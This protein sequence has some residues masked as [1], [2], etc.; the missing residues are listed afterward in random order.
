PPAPAAPESPARRPEPP[1]VSAD[2]AHGPNRRRPAVVTALLLIV[3]VVTAVV[4]TTGG[5]GGGGIE[6]EVTV[7]GGA[8]WVASG[9]SVEPGDILTVKVSGSIVHDVDADRSTGPDGDPSPDV[10]QFNIVPDF[11]HGGLIG[12]VGNDGEPFA[13]GKDF[14]ATAETAGELFLQVNDVGL[15]SNAGEFKARVSVKRAR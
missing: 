8:S 10:Q 12:H 4:L 9:V 6:R 13:I 5:D 7:G 3:V 14:T 2:Q 1:P 11:L 15:D